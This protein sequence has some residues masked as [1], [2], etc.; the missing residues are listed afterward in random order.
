M[1]NKIKIYPHAEMLH[2]KMHFM[3]F[4]KNTNLIDFVYSLN[5]TF[6][7]LPIYDESMTIFSEVTQIVISYLKKGRTNYKL[8]YFTGIIKK[9]SKKNKDSISLNLLLFFDE[10]S[11][12]NAENKNQYSFFKNCEDIYTTLNEAINYL[13]KF[14]LIENKHPQRIID[15]SQQVKLYQRAHS[16]KQLLKKESHTNYELILSIFFL[17]KLLKYNSN[18]DNNDNLK[19]DKN[20]ELKILNNNFDIA[21]YDEFIN[22]HYKNDKNILISFNTTIRTLTI[23]KIGKDLNAYKG[24]DIE[25]LF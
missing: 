24:K 13:E 16:L 6:R 4:K 19:G 18:L 21:L 9:Y 11:N 5:K 2:S 3:I 1:I 8:Y 25:K 10:V 17:D 23:N 14:I 7:D 12:Q 22:S 20:D 15:A